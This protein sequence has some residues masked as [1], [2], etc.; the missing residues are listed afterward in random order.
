M[1]RLIATEA[2]IVLAAGSSDRDHWHEADGKLEMV[3]LQGGRSA[4]YRSPHPSGRVEIAQIGMKT[5]EE[6]AAHEFAGM[7]YFS[8][9]GARILR[10]VYHDCLVTVDGPF[11]EADSFAHASMTDLLQEVVDRGF[12]VHGLEVQRARVEI[13]KQQEVFQIA[14]ADSDGGFGNG[15]R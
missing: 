5:I 3:A 9:Q 6:R 13:P 11:H 8:K 7:A 10:K 2:E 1:R 14:A 4:Q 12:A 15:R